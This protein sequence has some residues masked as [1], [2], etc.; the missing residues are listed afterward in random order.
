MKRFVGP[1]TEHGYALLAIGAGIHV[2]TQA[3]TGVA[4][5]IAIGLG[6]IGTGIVFGFKRPR[7]RCVGG[8]TAVLGAGRSKGSR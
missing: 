5:V 2:L 6:V 8:P 1:G 3:G 4:Y 7:D